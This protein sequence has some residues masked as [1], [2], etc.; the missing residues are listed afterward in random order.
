MIMK[1]QQEGMRR[2]GSGAV[3]MVVATLLFCLDFTMAFVPSA[4]R[5]ARPHGAVVAHRSS[6]SGSCSLRM[7]LN[8]HDVM[9]HADPAWLSHVFQGVADAAVAT[10]DTTTATV[11]AVADAAEKEPGFFDKFVNVVMGAIESVHAGLVSL[12]V[13]GAYGT[14][15]ILFTSGVKLALLPVTYKQLESAQRMQALAPKAKELKDKYGKNKALLNQLT[16]KLYEDAE[17]NPLAGCLP[18]LAQ[19]PIFIALYRSLINLAGNSDF[20]EPFLWLPSL[21]G[22]V[23]GQQ[24]GMD[25]LT[26]NWVENV[27]S[28]GWHDTI[29]YL[30]IPCILILT[31]SISQRLLTPPSDDPK[32]AQTQRILKYLPLMV[33]YFSLSV[34]SG[35]G[36][37]W[38][39]NNLISTAISLTIKEKFARNP[40]VID[41]DVDPEDLGYDPST[42]VMSFEDMMAEAQQNALP[43]REPKRK[44]PTPSAAGFTLAAKGSDSRSS[45][46]DGFEGREGGNGD[47]Q[48][49]GVGS[50]IEERE[51]AGVDA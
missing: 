16:A 35:L 30:S 14:A 38:I 40:I 44:R 51:K 5:L 46:S 1:Q 45:I 31:Q 21:A 24:R 29:A 11:D 34:P 8:P 12:G 36:L 2:R 25:W 3:W 4:S 9:G 10:L 43:S 22:P 48:E 50:K 23:Y 33:G 6:S 28:L 27:P 49:G 39:T 13:P 41:V 7:I 32:A 37:Y 18:A 47:E 20:N 17:V 15:I 42:V 26:Q 19:I